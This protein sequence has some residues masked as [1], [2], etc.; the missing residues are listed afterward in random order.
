MLPTEIVSCILDMLSLADMF[1][2][3]RALAHAGDNFHV[4]IGGFLNVTCTR[5]NITKRIVK[6]VSDL[7]RRL[8]SPTMTHCKECGCRCRRFVHVCKRCAGDPTGFRS[9]ITRKEIKEH[10]VHTKKSY[11]AVVRKLHP[12]S[13]SNTGAFLYWRAHVVLLHPGTAVSPPP[14]STTLV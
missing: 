11:S 10:C 7:H 8:N 4:E 14:S 2:L 5:M 3:R 1:R 12:V 9:L 13:I 6:T